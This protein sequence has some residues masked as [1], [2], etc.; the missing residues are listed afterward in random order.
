MTYR[1]GTFHEVFFPAVAG[2]LRL[3]KSIGLS[4]RVDT[5]VDEEM[6]AFDETMPVCGWKL[7]GRTMRFL[8]LSAYRGN[9]LNVGGETRSRSQS[10]ATG[11]GACVKPLGGRE[12]CW[13][14]VHISL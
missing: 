2:F 7:G 4:P 8:K 11:L 6:D 1:T 3:K 10:C 5:M 9:S 13:G 12:V 14:N